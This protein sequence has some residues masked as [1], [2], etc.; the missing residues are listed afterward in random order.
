MYFK[1][2]LNLLVEI[3][4]IIIIIYKFIIMSTLKNRKSRLHHLTLLNNLH[5]FEI[6]NIQFVNKRLFHNTCKTFYSGW[7]THPYVLLTKDEPE[8]NDIYA[9]PKGKRSR[10]TYLRYA[11]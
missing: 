4:F 1:K 2:L 11:P 5:P 10:S 8:P 3:E 6:L 9:I 7:S